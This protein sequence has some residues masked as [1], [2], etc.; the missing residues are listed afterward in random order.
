M[1]DGPLIS[2]LINNYN[3]APYLSAA[4]DSALEQDYP[5]KEIIVAD[6]RSTD[7]SPDIIRGY[8]D[9]IMA[10]H[11]DENGGQANPINKGFEHCRGALVAMLD[12]D[13]LFMP[14]KLAQIATLYRS[15]PHATLYCDP[16]AEITH[17]GTVLGNRLPPQIAVGDLR[18]KAAALGGLWSIPPMSGLTFSRSVLEMLLPL[19]VVPH[20][21][22]VDHYLATM[23]GFLGAIAALEEPMTW[24]RVHGANMYRHEARLRRAH[25]TLLDDV[26]R[27]DRRVF[28]INETMSRLNLPYR[29]RSD[30]RLWYMI[31]RYRAGQISWWALTRSL[32]HTVRH[33]GLKDNWRLYRA[34]M[35]ARRH[36]N[37]L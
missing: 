33:I 28:S 6:D 1:S 14:G 2:V 13:D 32:I 27:M 18:K 35:R 29:L 37:R 7:V 8:G 23:A 9:R 21:V 10:V 3:Y 11:C 16:I 25:W 22:G 24:R 19:Q 34:A 15:Q 5:H 4:I 12:S 17:D 30:D 31:C 36:Q 20:R 26:Q